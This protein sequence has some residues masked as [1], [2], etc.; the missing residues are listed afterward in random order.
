[1]IGPGGIG[2][3]GVLPGNHLSG[4]TSL[5][6][7]YSLS[8]SQTI[9]FTQQ[10][11]RQR[12]SN[13]NGMTGTIGPGNQFGP[14]GPMNANN[15]APRHLN[16]Q[17]LE[18][19]KLLQQQMLRAQQV[20]QH[21]R[22]PPPDYKTSAGMIQGMQP[23]YAGVPPNVRRCLQPMPPSGPMMMRPHNMYMMQQQHMNAAAARGVYPRQQTTMNS[24]DNIPPQGGS[25]EWRHMLISQQQSA[26]F[27]QQM[28]PNFQQ[29]FNMN[30]GNMSMSALQHQQ[31]RVQQG[32]VGNSLGQGLGQGISQGQ[33]MS[34]NSPMSQMNTLNQQIMTHMQQQQSVMQQNS[35]QMSMSSIHMQQTQSVSMTNQTLQQQ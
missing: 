11:L 29:G 28:R 9:N 25:T 16:P 21:V 8:Q 2:N 31:L 5:G 19:Q 17:A 34:Q 4:Q 3:H 1:M 10:T 23:R 26:N 35:N 12:A 27:T 24:M 20:Q 6:D 14:G 7:T 22:P 13:T 15:M 32:V 18:H 30:S 33:V